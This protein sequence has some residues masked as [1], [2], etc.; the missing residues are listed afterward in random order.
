MKPSSPETG[1]GG[2]EV[3]GGAAHDGRAGTGLAGAAVSFGLFGVGLFIIYSICLSVIQFQF[4]YFQPGAFSRS[5]ETYTP[6][7]FASGSA[8][9]CIA[10]GCAWL[11]V[12]AHGCVWL[13]IIFLHFSVDDFLE[14]PFSSGFPASG[15]LAVHWPDGLLMWKLSHRG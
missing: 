9:K 3:G 14:L 11:L 4:S 5:R 2:S 1:E 6:G 13:R 8:R 7:F 15:Y 12:V 10:R